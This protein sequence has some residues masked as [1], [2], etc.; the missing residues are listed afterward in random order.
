MIIRCTENKFGPK[1]T[2]YLQ[3]GEDRI[4][5]VA[6]KKMTSTNYHIYDMSRGAPIQKKLSKKSGNYLGKLKGVSGKNP[7]YSLYTNSNAKEQMAAFKFTKV[8]LTKQIKVGQLPRRLHVLIPPVSEEG[9]HQTYKTAADSDMLE[10]F[11]NKVTGK[12]Q[13]FVTKEPTFE[14][15]QYRLNFKGRVTTPSVKN[16]QI[17]HTVDGETQSKTSDVIVQ[18]GRVAENSFH[19]DFKKPFNAFQAFAMA[20]AQFDL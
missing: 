12:M 11:K 13:I 10:R 16:F 5:L 2:L 4:E 8:G 20:L 9:V 3:D 18:F 7:E 19:L 17:V 6:M 15:G 1:Y 14:R